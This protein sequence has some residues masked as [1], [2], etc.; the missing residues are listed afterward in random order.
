[1]YMNCMFADVL[2]VFMNIHNVSIDMYS[3]MCMYFCI[4]IF[5]CMHL[6][7]HL[8]IY[9]CICVCVY[10]MIFK[11]KSMNSVRDVI[12]KALLA[13]SFCKCAAKSAA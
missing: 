2:D 6:F 4:C 12:L 7:V 1:M 10:Y 13:G 11:E 9:L 5:L 8:C 3:W